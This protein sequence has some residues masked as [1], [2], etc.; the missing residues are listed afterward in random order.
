MSI[1]ETDRP[2]QPH[3]L[4]PGVS[5][6]KPLSLPQTVVLTNTHLTRLPQQPLR[7]GLTA[8]LAAGSLNGLPGEGRLQTSR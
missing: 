4:S 1:R 8:Q 2:L 3:R 7:P 6:L 5:D